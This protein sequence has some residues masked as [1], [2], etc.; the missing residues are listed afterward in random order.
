MNMSTT[1]N[2]GTENPVEQELERDAVARRA[3][4]LW[5]AAGRSSG[6]DMEFWLKAQ[7]DLHPARN[8]RPEKTA[9][10]G[11]SPKRE[12]AGASASS[13]QAS[14]AEKTQRSKSATSLS[15]GRT[16]RAA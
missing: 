1:K 15:E 6:R 4:Q 9:A 2:N 12:T 8:N 13:P 16:Q 5:E 14:R 10:S 11:S 7:A 3:Y